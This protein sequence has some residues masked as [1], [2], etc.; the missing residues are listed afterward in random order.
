MV[1]TVIFHINSFVA[2]AEFSL[3]I[4]I[5]KKNEKREYS[6][7]FFF[8]KWLQLWLKSWSKE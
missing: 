8:Y 5:A 4:F 3:L 6:I 2:K 7:I 1:P